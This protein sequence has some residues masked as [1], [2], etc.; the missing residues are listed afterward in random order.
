MKTNCAVAVWH[1][2]DDPDQGTY[3]LPLET[4]WGDAPVP[5][6]NM[7]T[8]EFKGVLPKGANVED[9]KRVVGNRVRCKINGTTMFTADWALDPKPA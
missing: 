8:W 6:L 5:L 1:K 4:P 3:A 2:L 9:A 7:Q